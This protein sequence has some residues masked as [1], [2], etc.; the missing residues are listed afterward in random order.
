MR[1][2]LILSILLVLIPFHA[3]ANDFWSLT[4]SKKDYL[5]FQLVEIE[6]RMNEEVTEPYIDSVWTKIAG[7]NGRKLNVEKSFQKLI[8]EKMERIYQ[9][10]DE[11]VIV[12]DIPRFK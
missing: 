12:L 4:F 5:Y 11:Y 1:K 10:L 7:L 6:E 3:K 2:W 9:L 8:V